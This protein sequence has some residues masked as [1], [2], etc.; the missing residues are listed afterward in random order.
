M[1]SEQLMALLKESEGWRD[2]PYLC[3]AGK[4][5]IGWG[6]TGPEVT[7][8]S[9]HISKEQGE[10]LLAS[11]IA[12]AETKLLQICPM[13]IGEPVPRIEAMIDFAFNFGPNRVK[14]TTLEKKIAV[15]DWIAAGVELRKWT[16]AVVD[17]QFTR[18]P[19]LIKRRGIAARWMADGTY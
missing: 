1:A 10:A 8:D 5:T 19:G 17:G 16:G 3:P 4:W 15:K 7:A 6:H 11:D 14:G 9:A 12:K 18:L 2:H 13:L